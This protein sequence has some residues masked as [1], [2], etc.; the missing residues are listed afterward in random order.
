MEQE[1]QK[2]QMMVTNNGCVEGET[3][4][5]TVFRFLPVFGSYQEDKYQKSKYILSNLFLSHVLKENFLQIL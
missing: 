5:L 4:L 3:K 2:A 1:R